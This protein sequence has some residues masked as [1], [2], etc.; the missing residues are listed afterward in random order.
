VK[1]EGTC[2]DR[3]VLKYIQTQTKVGEKLAKLNA[4][5]AQQMAAQGM[6]PQ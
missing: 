1:G 6:A 3:C 4:D 2:I 5:Q